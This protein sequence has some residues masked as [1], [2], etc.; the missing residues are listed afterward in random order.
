MIFA[1]A[2]ASLSDMDNGSSFA[3]TRIVMVL[4]SRSG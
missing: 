3:V 4:F 1:I 2:N